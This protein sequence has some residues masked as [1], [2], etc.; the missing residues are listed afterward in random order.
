[1]PTICGV[2][3][4]VVDYECTPCAG[5]KT[6]AGGDF[7]PLNTTDCDEVYVA[8]G[9]CVRACVLARVRVCVCFVLP[10]FSARLHSQRK[11]SSAVRPQRNKNLV[12]RRNRLNGPTATRVVLAAPI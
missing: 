3:E 8:C 5:N 7:A 4:H 2:D 12:P 10:F 11:Q 9:V 1:M 6:N